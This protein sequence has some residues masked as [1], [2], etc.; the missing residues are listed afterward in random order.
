MTDI[1]FVFESISKI[2]DI[3]SST[4]RCEVLDVNKLVRNLKNPTSP[5]ALF[6]VNFKIS[7]AISKCFSIASHSLIYINSNINSDVVNAIRENPAIKDKIGKCIIVDNGI[8][9]K[10]RQMYKWFDEVVFYTA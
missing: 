5:G 4:T 10:H 2:P 1:Y 3:F 8:T 7:E 9:M 6:T